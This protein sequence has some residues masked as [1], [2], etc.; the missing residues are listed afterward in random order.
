MV[1]PEHTEDL[2]AFT[3]L[4]TLNERME[5]TR[6]VSRQYKSTLFADPET[7]ITWRECSFIEGD[8]DAEGKLAHVIFTTKSI[9]EVKAKELETLKKI[10][11]E[12]EIA[13][14][15]SRDYPDVVLLDLV[16]DTAVTIKREG[17]MIAEDQRVVRRSY[18]DTWNYYIEKYKKSLSFL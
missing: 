12:M 11:D 7:G 5:N 14:A 18:K 8:R 3:D 9:H 2:L 13:G 1:V 17:N 6:I 10:R 16:R 15:L 4:S